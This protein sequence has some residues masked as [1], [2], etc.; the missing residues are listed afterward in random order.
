VGRG[1]LLSRLLD[2]AYL[3]LR[4]MGTAPGRD[5][6]WAVPRLAV[7]WLSHG[8]PVGSSVRV[9]CMVEARPPSQHPPSRVRQH[10]WA[11]DVFDGRAGDVR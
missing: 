9:R 7:V 1:T 6:L 10:P 5:V 8:V 4:E 11:F 3:T 2:A